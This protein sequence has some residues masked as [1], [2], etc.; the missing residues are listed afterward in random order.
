MNNSNWTVIIGVAG[1]I[2]GTI[3]GWVLNWLS[4]CGKLRVY[5]ISWEDVFKCGRERAS[6]YSRSIETTKRWVLHT[7]L[8]LY[9][10]SNSTKSMRGLRIVLN[11]GRKDL[12]EIA[13]DKKQTEGTVSKYVSIG[14]IHI[15]AKMTIQLDLQNILVYGDEGFDCIWKCKKIFLLYKDG[16]DRQKR[17]LLKTK[18]YAN[19]F[20]DQK[21][22]EP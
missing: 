14:V 20:N 5:V 10:G 13:P 3:L 1:T 9:N 7:E 15:P 11:D 4:N 12:C 22:E 18:D 17:V 19:H 16:K 6:G 2:C 21:Q 8:E